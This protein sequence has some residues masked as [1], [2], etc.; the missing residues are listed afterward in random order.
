M[1]EMSTASAGRN[2]FFRKLSKK[3]YR[4]NW[5]WGWALIAPTIIGLFILNIYPFFYTIYLST[6]KSQGLGKA[7]YV[8]LQ[9]YTK[10][11]NDPMLWNATRN[12]LLFVLLTVPVGVMISLVLAAL[13]NNKIRFRDGYRAIYFLPMV[14]AP[15]AVAMVWKW[16]FNSDCGIL[17]Q[18]LGIFGIKG[19]TWI[20][21]P[22]TALLSCAIINIWSAVGYD[23]VL[24]L[25]G[26]QGISKSYYEAAEIDGATPIQ[27]FFHI[28]VP[29]ISP[30]LFFVVLMRTM[31]SLK[32][33]DTVYLLVKADNPAYKSTATLMTLF[34]REAFEKFNKGYASAIVL[35]SFLLISVF[36]TIQFIAEKKLVH[37]E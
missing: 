6:M 33:F 10:L 1:A 30:T 37:Y 11:L 20:A 15:A 19:P 22:K 28:T 34:Y 7:K 12:T 9:N 2:G 35:L 31:T 27:S 26:L 21:D 32:Q 36:T 29:L 25:A 4:R 5:A 13:L 14:V 18:F 17:N 23:L 8:G 3:S 16:I 24:I